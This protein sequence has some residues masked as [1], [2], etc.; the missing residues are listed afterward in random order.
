MGTLLD[1][2]LNTGERYTFAQF[3]DE[4]GLDDIIEDACRFLLRYF[5]GRN[6]DDLRQCI[7]ILKRAIKK[8]DKNSPV[9]KWP[10]ALAAAKKLG[11]EHL[12]TRAE[13]VLLANTAYTSYSIYVFI[14]R[15]KMEKLLKGVPVW[16]LT[17][18]L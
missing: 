10:V 18:K 13:C 7:K 8:R 12:L 15:D 6:K 14:L 17:K 16:E 1:I 9:P 3:A 11:A 5:I 4:L 2:N